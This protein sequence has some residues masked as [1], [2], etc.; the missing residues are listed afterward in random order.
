MHEASIAQSILNTVLETASKND[1]EK[2]LR[3]EMEVGEICLVNVDQLLYITGLLAQNTIARDMEFSVNEV[4]T[5]IRCQ[6]CSYFG[7]VKYKEADPSWHYNV[8]IFTCV[9]CHS[10]MTEIVQGKEMTIKS[11]DVC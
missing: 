9:R 2:V 4:K 6:N 7:G 8:P 11:I 3:V 5:K 1:A 10:N